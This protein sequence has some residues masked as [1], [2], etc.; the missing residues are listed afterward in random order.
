MP[1][2]VLLE[3]DALDDELAGRAP[4]PGLLPLAGHPMVTYAA[5]AFRGC[6]DVD[7]LVLAGPDDY[8]TQPAALAEFDAEPLLAPTVAERVDLALDRYAASD[9][10]LFWPANAPLLTPDAVE[11]FLSHAPTGAG[12]CWSCVRQSR[13]E[14][15]FGELPHLP[16]HRFGADLLALG[17][18]GAVRP[19]ALD[20]QRDLVRKMLGQ[21]LVKSELIKLLGVGFAI[22]F[23]SFRATL[24]DLMTKIGD[25]LGT[26]CVA[27]ILPHPE[28]CFRVRNRAEHHLARARLE[29][30]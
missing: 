11:C 3:I 8:R 23:S 22:K 10:L 18:L 25:V 30:R 16:K 2:V 29:E 7:Q 19:A 1:T 26:D 4:A 13:V 27:T 6:G 21:P 17:S 20:G 12:L 24:S 14:A 9:E 15:A 5:R 28:L